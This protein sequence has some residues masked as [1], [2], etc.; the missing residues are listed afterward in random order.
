MDFRSTGRGRDLSLL[1]I[2]TTSLLHLLFQC[3]AYDDED[4]RLDSHDY[5]C[6]D[7][8]KYVVEG[9]EYDGGQAQQCHSRHIGKYC[10]P[11]L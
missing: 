10:P 9:D 11:F 7:G 1:F 2:G 3:I 6:D 8:G 4:D 5:A